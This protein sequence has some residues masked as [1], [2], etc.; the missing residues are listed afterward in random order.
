[1][2]RTLDASNQPGL[3]NASG[4]KALNRPISR[5]NWLLTPIAASI[6]DPRAPDPITHAPADNIRFRLLMRGAVYADELAARRNRSQRSIRHALLLTFP[7]PAP[8]DAACSGSLPRGYGV[9][10]P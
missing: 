1:M 7:D 4:R 9:S 5:M 2:L 3:C 6:L 10:C 8:I